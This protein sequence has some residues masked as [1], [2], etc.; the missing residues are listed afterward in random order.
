MTK[1]QVGRYG[2]LNVIGL[3]KLIENG[4][5]RRYDLVEVSIAL[6]EEV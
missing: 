1:T 4:T 2:S 6:L 3:C 5:N